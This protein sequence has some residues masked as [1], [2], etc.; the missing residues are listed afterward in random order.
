MWCRYPNHLDAQRLTRPERVHGD[1]LCVGAA[2]RVGL[3]AR[4]LVALLKGTLPVFRTKTLANQFTLASLFIITLVS[5][6]STTF[7]LGH[8]T[9]ILTS[10]LLCQI[11]TTERRPFQY[12]DK[13]KDF[14]KPTT[15]LPSL[16]AID[17]DESHM[18]L[19]P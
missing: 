7:G 2:R 13:N 18:D 11:S 19:D 17:E 15:T 12:L 16:I 9:C 14:D 6:K 5:A 10:I 8:F 3:K 4:S 1:A